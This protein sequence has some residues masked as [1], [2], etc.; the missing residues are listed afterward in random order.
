MKLG[1]YIELNGSKFECISNIFQIIDITEDY[2]I[3]HHTEY[4]E[5]EKDSGWW[6]HKINK[7]GLIAFKKEDLDGVEI[8]DIKKYCDDRGL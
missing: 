5:F 1:D 3:L 2:I 4:S 8:V 7:E 6:N